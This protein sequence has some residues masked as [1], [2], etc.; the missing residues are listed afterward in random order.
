MAVIPFSST[1]R[2]NT[3]TSG[4]AVS[5]GTYDQLDLLRIPDVD[6]MFHMLNDGSALFYRILSMLSKEAPADQPRFEY[7]EDDKYSVRTTIASVTSGGGA[8]NADDIVMELTEGLA[9]V[10]TVIY[11]VTTEEALLVTAAGGTGNTTVT[12]KRSHQGTSNATAVVATNELILIGATLPEGADA[13][14]GIA[15]LPTKDYNFTSFFSQGCN[16]T[17]IQE[18]TNMLNGTGQLNNEFRKQTLFLMEQIDQALRYSTRA[19]TTID[20]N[21]VYYTGGFANTIQ[22]DVLLAGDPTLATP[23]LDWHELNA[24]FNE[25]FLPTS[26]SPTKTLLCG[27]V[28]FSAINNISWGHYVDG[29]TP[30]FDTTLGATMSSIV[31]DGGGVI[32]VV[33][34]KYGFQSAA[35]TAT[36]FLIDMGNIALKPFNGFDMVWRE[37]TAPQSHTNK[38]ELFSSAGMKILHNSTHAKVAWQETDI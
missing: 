27:Q 8:T 36:G 26:S 17:D 24:A 28:L 33:L 16:S 6:P 1:G 19:Y 30:T 37:V 38:Y 10:N 25:Y 2:F 5:H 4:I 29:G 18:L 9:S 31:L 32:D 20:S 35:Q 12:V 14:D 23:T 21:P 3:Q 15:I 11:N 7:F 34:D 22:G 13:N